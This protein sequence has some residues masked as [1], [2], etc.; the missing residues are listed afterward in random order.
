MNGNINNVVNLINSISP[1]Y[2]LTKEQVN[3]LIVKYQNDTRNIE[4]IKHEI[5]QNHDANT[6]NSNKACIN[7]FWQK[8][9][10]K[11]QKQ[12]STNGCNNA[13]THDFCKVFD[14]NIFKKSTFFEHSKV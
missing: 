5:E 6:N 7:K 8:Q 2:G 4:N 12:F 10:E 11:T 13:I 3:E 14:E 1:K 9:L